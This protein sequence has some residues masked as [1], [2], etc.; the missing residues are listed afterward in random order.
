M[1]AP[2][3]QNSECA[4]GPLHNL[5]TPWAK[6]VP[7]SEHNPSN[8]SVGMALPNKLFDLAQNEW[9][10][11]RSVQVNGKKRL[12]T[13]DVHLLVSRGPILTQS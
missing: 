2:H 12:H 4:V 13:R 10:Q 9:S 11:M 5:S 7:A 8:M 6:G 3:L 1:P